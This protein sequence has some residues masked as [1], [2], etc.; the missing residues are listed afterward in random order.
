MNRNGMQRAPDRRTGNR[1]RGMTLVEIMV[2]VAIIGLVMGAVAIGA[3]PMLNRANCK[4]AWSETQT[5]AQ[6]IAS[7]Q[8]ENNG[9]CPHSLDE[10]V[11]G[12]FLSKPP[13]DPWGQPFNYKCPGEKVG[14]GADIWSKGRNKQDG[15]EDDVRGW[16]RTAG[17]RLPQL[18]PAPHRAPRG[19]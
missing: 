9:D 10:L 7:Y 5:I 19:H 15:D 1:S 2:V 3:I 16:S 11:Q 14:D 18:M 13:I 6:A 17:R 8:M 12:K 4:T